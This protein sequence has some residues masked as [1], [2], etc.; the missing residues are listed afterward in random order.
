MAEPKIRWRQKFDAASL[1]TEEL[2][3]KLHEATEKVDQQASYIDT[4][5]CDLDDARKQI[6]RARIQGMNDVT[7]MLLRDE[8]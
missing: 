8:K 6:E 5:Q 4:L 7:T 3:R 1:E 2:K